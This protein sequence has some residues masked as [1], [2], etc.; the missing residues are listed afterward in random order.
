MTCNFLFLDILLLQIV[1][2]ILL[3]PKLFFENNELKYS[4]VFTKGTSFLEG[5]GNVWQEVMEKAPKAYLVSLQRFSHC[6]YH[7]VFKCYLQ[8]DVLIAGW[9]CLLATG[10]VD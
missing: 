1:P 7:R 3:F 5:K 10:T 9:F 8:F 2:L 6:G 4:N